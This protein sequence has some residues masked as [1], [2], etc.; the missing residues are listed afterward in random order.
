MNRFN[1][2]LEEFLS[3]GFQLKSHLAEYLGKT[4]EEL[5]KDLSSGIKRNGFLTPRKLKE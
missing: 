3:N 2:H 1:I 4:D 5:E